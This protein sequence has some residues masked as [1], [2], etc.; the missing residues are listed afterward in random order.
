MVD[1]PGGYQSS[2]SPSS[3]LQSLTTTTLQFPATKVGWE[4]AESLSRHSDQGGR[5]ELLATTG[6]VLRIWELKW[7]TSQ[8]SKPV[9]YG[10]NGYSEGAEGWKLHQRSLLSNS[11]QHV[12]NLPP[13]TS[14]SW[15]P[16]S[17]QSIVTCSTDT[18][19]TLW[20]ITTSQALTQLIAHDRAVY[21]LS[22]LPQSSDIFVSVGA[23][24]SLRAFDLRQLEH[25]TI[26]Y[27]TPNSSPLA[28][29]AFS[30]RE[31][32][33]CCYFRLTKDTCSHA[34]AWT[35]SAH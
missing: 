14:F 8:D 32:Y 10:R 28:R 11:K 2:Y 9:G 1:T 30:N 17:P 25:S 6:D 29:I 27:E 20:D 33:V 26:L 23:D 5:G 35:T 16:T 12:S 22:W 4:P 24:G 3:D 21:D 31:Q 15:N 18:T 13:I 34:L 7:E 19:A